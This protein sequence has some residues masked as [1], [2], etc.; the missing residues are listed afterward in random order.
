MPNSPQLVEEQLQR[1][2]WGFLADQ[3]GYLVGIDLGG[4]GLRVALV[5]LHDHTY[6]SVHAETTTS[7]PQTMLAETLDLTRSLLDQQSV[8][9]ERLVRIGVGFGAPVD[10]DRGVVLSS[11]RRPGWEGFALKE[12]FEQAFDTVTMVDNDANLIALGE[13][14]FG[15]GHGCPH[16]FYLHLSSGVGGGMVLDNRLYHGASAIAGEIGHAVVG[17]DW[18]EEPTATLE[19]LVSI[20]GLL[21]RA[22]H[23]GLSTENLNDLFSDNPIGQQ[24]VAEAVNILAIRMAHVIALLDPRMIVLGGIVV[25][26]GGEGLVEAIARQMNQYLAPA[27]ARP[28][29][30]VASVLGADSIAIGALA[31]ALDSL[32]D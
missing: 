19:Q 10:Y 21:R 5:N 17:S 3:Q 12:A 18:V 26:L 24:V 8:P 23:L 2:N 1:G 28:V 9:S 13:A 22:E 27:I 6:T 14:T 4:Y 31:L 16:L 25:R 29:D 30:V 32:Q 20:G 7:D 15:I 11:P